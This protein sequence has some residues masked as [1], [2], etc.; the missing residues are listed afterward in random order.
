MLN[1]AGFSIKGESEVKEYGSLI[2]TQTLKI[3]TL[4]FWDPPAEGQ[5]P[6][7][8]PHTYMR[9][10]DSINTAENKEWTHTL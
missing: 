7:F 1:S 2:E 9:S 10:T 3:Y 4:T 8:E 6:V 5:C